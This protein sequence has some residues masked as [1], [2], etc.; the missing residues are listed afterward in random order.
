MNPNYDA[1]PLYW[2]VE[3]ALS[4][5][6]EYL[7]DPLAYSCPKCHQNKFSRDSNGTKKNVHACFKCT[8][9]KSKFRA[10][11][12]SQKVMN[13][14]PH[15]ETFSSDNDN[16][17]DK[18]NDNDND[19]DNN[20]MSIPASPYLYTKDNSRIFSETFNDPLKEFTLSDLPQVAR[21][22]QAVSPLFVSSD[23]I[24]KSY[25]D[26]QMQSLKEF[27]VEYINKNSNS[28]SPQPENPNTDINRVVQILLKQNEDLKHQINILQKEIITLKNVNSV[29]P[30]NQSLSLISDHGTDNNNNNN[31]QLVSNPTP[32]VSKPTFAQIAKKFIKPD[33]LSNPLNVQIALRR[34][35][36]VKPPHTTTKAEVNHQVCR[37]YVQGIQRQSIKDLKAS[38]FELRFQLSKIWSIDFI[39]KM[40]AEFTIS[41]SYLNS[42]R[43]KIKNIPF[44]KILP[45]IDPSKPIDPKASSVSVDLIKNAFIKRLQNSYVNTK[46][47]EFKKF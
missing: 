1:L 40:T 22:R 46:K 44:M 37:I 32:Q 20:S 18:D 15:D 10:T 19:N 43:S 16:D 47:P 12:F 34:I 7:K 33:N 24:S 13:I 17:N 11:E 8:S 9:C 25:I 38:L 6:K 31:N 45:N 14:A 5:L 4:I 26:E 29:K 41:A 30:S 3:P 39:G 27:M 2:K 36:G 28:S 23:S 35:A 42:F 21:K